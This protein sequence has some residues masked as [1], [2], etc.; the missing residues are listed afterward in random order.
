MSPASVILFR[1]V[2]GWRK[3]PWDWRL[4]VVWNGVVVVSSIWVFSA[5][6]LGTERGMEYLAAG[7]FV[8]R[9][10]W[11]LAYRLVVAGLFAVELIALLCLARWVWFFGIMVS[12]V[13]TAIL[14]IAVASGAFH[15]AAGMSGFPMQEE[16]MHARAT[17]LFLAVL[18]VPVGLLIW[19]LLRKKALLL[20]IEDHRDSSAL[21]GAATDS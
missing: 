9:S 6:A 17:A 4:L 8:V 7:P 21:R 12:S 19:R 13:P 10:T 14:I 18:L 3:L 16:G 15:R 5:A 20:A 2:A 11:A 1:A